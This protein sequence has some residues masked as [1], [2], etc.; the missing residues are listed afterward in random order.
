M[1]VQ[2]TLGFVIFLEFKLHVIFVGANTHICN[3]YLVN[4]FSLRFTVMQCS[5]WCISYWEKIESFF[6]WFYSSACTVHCSWC[7]LIVSM[8]RGPMG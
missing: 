4:F 6:Y 1:H 3:W 5:F 8:C 2:S 7:S